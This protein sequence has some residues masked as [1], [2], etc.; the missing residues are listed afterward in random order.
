M[1]KFF[2][3]TLLLLLGVHCTF[4]LAQETSPIEIPLRYDVSL[5]S[6]AEL[7]SFTTIQNTMQD[8]LGFLWIG[9]NEGLHCLD[10]K[11]IITYNTSQ[12]TGKIGVVSKGEGFFRTS[13]GKH[14]IL[15]IMENTSGDIIG[16]D[17]IKRKEVRRIQM[18]DYS[19]GGLQTLENAETYFVYTD[20]LEVTW[21][22]CLTCNDAPRKKLLE[23]KT[24]TNYVAF[25]N[26]HWIHAS[27]VFY[28]YSEDGELIKAY[29]DLEDHYLNWTY[30][31]SLSFYKFL[32]TDPKVYDPDLQKIVRD[33]MVPQKF[34]D[35]SYHHF[36]KGNEVWLTDLHHDFYIWNREDD[37]LQNYTDQISELLK[38]SAYAGLSGDFRY[39]L[40]L[41]DGSILYS[42]FNSL[43]RFTRKKVNDE[44]YRESLYSNQA[45]TS[46]RGLAEDERG[47][48]YAAYYTGVDVKN[49]NETVFRPFKDT[50]TGPREAERTYSLTYWTNKLIWD[51]AV[52]DLAT[53]DQSHIMKDV[54]GQHVNH[55]IES[56]T[57][58]LY[59][60]YANTL[61]KYNANGTYELVTDSLISEP[62]VVS[63]M[64]V[65]VESRHLWFATQYYGIMI[66]SK[67]GQLVKQYDLSA[68]G[69]PA[70]KNNIYFLE[71]EGDSL[72]FGTELGIGLL[73]LKSQKVALF[74][75]PTASQTGSETL[76]KMY[77]M[78]KD[79]EGN[80]YLG[81]DHGICYFD[82]KNLR[83]KNLIPRHPLANIEF[84]RNSTLKASNGK[85]YFG[86]IDGLYAFRPDQLKFEDNLEVPKPFLSSAVIY[87]R[88]ESEP[89]IFGEE[90]N[91][92]GQIDLKA[93]DTDLILT[94]GAPSF[95]HEVFYRYKIPG[96]KN[97][98]S[99]YSS[100]NKLEFIS[101]PSGKY[102]V[103][104]RTYLK[105]ES[106]NFE[107]VTFEIWKPEVWYKRL[108]AQMLFLLL[109]GA[110]VYY[111]V[112]AKYVREIN[113]RKADE[114]LRTK[115]SSDLHDDVGTLLSGVALQSEFMSYEVDAAHKDGM[116]EISAMSREAME[117]MR[118]IVWAMDSRKDKFANLI[119]RMR[120]YAERNLSKK[121]IECRFTV[122]GIEKNGQINPEARQNI[123]LIFKESITNVIRHSNADMVKVYFGKI[124]RN[125]TLRVEDNG[126][127]VELSPTDGAGLSNI[128]MRAERIGGFVEFSNNEGFRMKLQ[129]PENI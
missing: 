50:R 28:Q 68:L 59:E 37:N 84:N 36:V 46:M 85:Y 31:D 61:V 124:G 42:K 55:A 47:S 103:N 87:N 82:K 18:Q 96:V 25:R 80:F 92:R 3:L 109:I 45:I 123:Y 39:E 71:F 121:E 117:R 86:S 40:E 127:N 62:P 7:S 22:A 6:P 64:K 51:F 115:L 114:Q 100:D 81:T 10:G 122:E 93:S 83:F 91:E 72:W 49:K 77:S 105:P 118:D 19:F 89:R 99:N 129:V 35:N 67:D 33:F 112:S 104:V 38:N 63:D 34:K 90:L 98:W 107:E 16:F 17:V 9:T 24:V 66:F 73:D 75:N 88:N 79:V 32:K 110:L 126:S 20:T 54:Y 74:K 2:L 27:S 76:R 29:T 12:N 48:I 8:S 108:W 30:G 128:K 120:A 78:L 60:W 119:D 95:E 116:N 56:D 65:D 52:F 11:D 4:L 14:N 97:E 1:S 53:G 15:W 111:F 21:L 58:W 44:L 70:M 106:E 69:L 125:L 43:I 94:I 41:D 113:K 102:D 13:L 23:D 57:L 26:E 101:F 5:V